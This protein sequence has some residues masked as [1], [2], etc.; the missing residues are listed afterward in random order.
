MAPEETLPA[1]QNAFDLGVDV[2]EM[3]A[4]STS[5]GVIVLMHDDDVS[6]TT[7]GDGLVSE[8]TYAELLALDAGY[9]FSSDNGATYP[10]R[11]TGVKVATLAEI[12][13]TFSGVLFSVEMKQLSSAEGVLAVIEEA[14]VLDRVVIASFSDVA[15]RKVRNLNS[16]LLTAMTLEE[17]LEFATLDEETIAT[18]SPI[19]WVIQTPPIFGDL[20]VNATLVERA[21]RF[22]IKLQLWTINEASE[23]Q[24]LL[25]LG[26][27]AIMSDDPAT[28]KTL[29]P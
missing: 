16:Q 9:W 8:M 20:E 26:V 27:H 3:D 29:I 4:R 6:R 18:Y 23:M 28:L 15:L 2:L 12:L 5:D 19:S 1:F 14:G 25:D 11:G 24:R 17:T 13:D 21:D 10:Y 7:D 22:G